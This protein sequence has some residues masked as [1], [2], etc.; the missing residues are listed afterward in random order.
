VERKKVTVR[1]DIYDTRSTWD[2]KSVGMRN[3]LSQV[4]TM[5]VIATLGCRTLFVYHVSLV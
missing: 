3:M 5:Q 2:C 4:F 1:Q